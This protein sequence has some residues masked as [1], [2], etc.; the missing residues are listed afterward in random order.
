MNPFDLITLLA[1]L[2]VQK[3]MPSFWSRWFPTTI[4]FETET[5]AFDEVSD[6]YRKMA[7]FVAPNVQGRVQKQ[8]GYQTSS[9]APA[10]VKPKDVVRPNQAIKR[11]AGE[12]LVTGTLSMQQRID[13]TVADL[14]ASQRIKIENRVEWMRAKA[15]ID[16]KITIEGRDYPKVTIDFNRDASLTTVLTGTA[17]WSDALSTPMKDLADARRKSNDLCGAVIRD[18]IFGANAFAL[19]YAKLD[20]TKIQN[21]TLRGSEG[22]VSAFLDGLEGVEFA[23][24]VSGVNGAGLMNLWV[25]TQKVRNEAGALVDVLDTNTVVGV[26]D[27]I[28]GVNCYGAIEDLGA[29]SA[30]EMYPKMW[31]DDDPS[32]MYVMTQSAPLPVPKMVNASFSMK[33]H[34]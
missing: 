10:Y 26:S 27:S 30:M 12:S 2:R 28:Q 11:R 21:N 5:I 33:V 23:G 9:Y 22:T 25:Y 17:K 20:P 24:T 18:F 15:L 1:V 19:F 7:P 13:A 34:S 14:L 29:L 8:G 6:D 3:T 32:A 31:A 16:G 4:T